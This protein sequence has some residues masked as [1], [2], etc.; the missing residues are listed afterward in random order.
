[1]FQYSRIFIYFFLF[2][3]IFFLFLFHFILLNTFSCNFLYTR[4]TPLLKIFLFNFYIC[5]HCYKFG[6]ILWHKIRIKEKK[7]IN[8]FS[9]NV[10]SDLFI[11]RLFIMLATNFFSFLFIFSFFLQIMSHRDVVWIINNIRFINFSNFF[12]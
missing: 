2:Y 4:D 12:A 1:M 6:F 5:P 9:H 8:S 3:L 10:I 7:T 11:E